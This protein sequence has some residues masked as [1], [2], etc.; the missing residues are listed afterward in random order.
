M[1]LNS[2]PILL[3]LS[4]SLFQSTDFLSVPEEISYLLTCRPQHLLFLCLECLPKY[5]TGSVLQQLQLLHKCHPLSETF[6]GHFVFICPV[7]FFFLVLI[8][9]YH[10]TY[11]TQL[12]CLLSPPLECKFNKVIPLMLKYSWNIIAT[13]QILNKQNCFSSLPA[14]SLL[15][16]F[17]SMQQKYNVKHQKR[18]KF[19]A[20]ALLNIVNKLS[21]HMIH[22]IFQSLK[23]AFIT[24]DQQNHFLKRCFP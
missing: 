4:C 21:P 11:F 7:L 24:C 1:P 12:S 23:L 15:T 19:N 8:T 9:I 22:K 17:E 5:A 13:H 16:R 6:L 3:S 14:E 18:K 20:S 2:L 10:T